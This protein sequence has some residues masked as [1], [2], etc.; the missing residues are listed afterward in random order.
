[1]QTYTRL[2]ASAASFIQGFD[3]VVKCIGIQRE[4]LSDFVGLPRREFN[5][6]LPCCVWHAETFP[7][8]LV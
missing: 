3:Q 7:Q 1:M 2:Q 6:R 5:E 8:H 4:K